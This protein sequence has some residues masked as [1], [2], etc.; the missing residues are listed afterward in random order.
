MHHQKLTKEISFNRIRLFS[1]LN[2]EQN[3][4]LLYVVFCAERWGRF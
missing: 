1:V 2:R 3:E 4:L